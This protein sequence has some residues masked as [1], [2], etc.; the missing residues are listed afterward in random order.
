MGL[1]FAR[2]V[3]GLQ[4]AFAN[5]AV[6][7]PGTDIAV[8]VPLDLGFALSWLLWWDCSHDHVS[9]LREQRSLV[10]L[11]HEV[12]DHVVRGTPLQR[13]I[14]LPDLIRHKIETDVDVLRVRAA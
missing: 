11:C 9:E 12:P 13:K 6:G 5:C 3:A 8:S 1:P 4:N 2:V 7:L 10:G 14:V